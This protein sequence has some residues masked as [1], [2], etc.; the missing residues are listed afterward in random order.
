MENRKQNPLLEEALHYLSYAEGELSR[1]EED[2]V[3]YCA[4]HFTRKSVMDMLKIFLDDKKKKTNDDETIQELYNRCSKVDSRFES[5]DIN[6]FG[7]RGMHN[8]VCDEKY[9][10]SVEHVNT[11]YAK[12]NE[13]KELVMQ[14]IKVPV[15]A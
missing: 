5:I 8:N 10:L 12:A 9:C 2:V 4:C 3:T 14:S 1:P 11:C 7:C 6:C 15:N 13:I